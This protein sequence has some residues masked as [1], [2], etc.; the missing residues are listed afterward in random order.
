M[1]W[2]LSYQL[3]TYVQTDFSCDSDKNA[4]GSR[5]LVMGSVWYMHVFWP[6]QTGYC[7]ENVHVFMSHLLS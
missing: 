6:L 4:S 1:V 2:T 7:Y 5:W 3:K